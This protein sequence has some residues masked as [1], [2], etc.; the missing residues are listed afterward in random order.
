[1]LA[2]ER[3]EERMETTVELRFRGESEVGAATSNYLSQ[4]L[5]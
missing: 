4:F 5:P 2:A 1:M 3:G